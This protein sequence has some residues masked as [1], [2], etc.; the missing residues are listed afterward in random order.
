MS[1]LLHLDSS[2]STEAD[3]ISRRLTALFAE[4]WR[5]RHQ[6]GSYRYR[7]LAVDPIPLVGPG[8][9]SLGIRVQQHGTPPPDQVDALVG[10]PDEQREWALTRPL[11]N[12]LLAAD[13]VLI[14]SPMYNLSVPAA[15][16]AWID[17]I[18]FPGAYTDPATGLN[19]LRHTRVVVALARGSSYRPGAPREGL[20]F[21]EPYL[22]AYFGNL[23]V[24]RPNLHLITADLT[25]A[26]QIPAMARFEPVAA[27]SLA[28]ARVQLAALATEPRAL[29]KG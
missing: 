28:S 7:D 4:A 13:T 18:T 8:Y 27:D 22:R 14:G 3:S 24:S 16:K 25:R 17:R 9:C 20:D 10:D 5:R 21:Q 11:I 15:L 26:A 1:S 2:A 12:E 29:V 19:R 6:H 23:G